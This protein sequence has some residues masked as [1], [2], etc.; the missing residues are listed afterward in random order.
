MVSCRIANSPGEHVQGSDA[1]ASSAASNRA[2]SAFTGATAAR[3]CCPAS[4]TAADTGVADGIATL[5]AMAEVVGLAVCLTAARNAEP[6]GCHPTK[7]TITSA[8]SASSVP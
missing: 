6:G 1:S 3:Y 8:T 2:P 7:A 4:A 5:G